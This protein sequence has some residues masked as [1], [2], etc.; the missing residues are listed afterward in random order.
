MSN[1][2]V[3]CGERQGKRECPALGGMICSRCCG[4]HRGVEINCS[5]DCRYF[6]KHEEFQQSKQAEAYRVT[7]V[8]KNEDLLEAEE[9]TLIDAIGVLELIILD[10]YRDDP[11][12]TDRQVIEGLK[13]LGNRFKKIEL[14]G[15]PSEFSDSAYED[16]KSLVESGKYT[17]EQLKEATARLRTVAEAFSDGSRR[18]VQGVVGR[19]KEDYDLPLEEPE[20]GKSKLESLITTPGE[21]NK[22]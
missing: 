3:Y 12:L 11:T 22:R 21:L 8:E 7:W 17:R 13:G 15:S 6:K 4:E 5:P 2:C 18:L 16:L 19:I 10:R 20:E 14:P 1:R 9:R